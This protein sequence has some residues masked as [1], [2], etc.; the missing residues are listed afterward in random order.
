MKSAYFVCFRWRHVCDT[1]YVQRKV[2]QNNITSFP[3]A[4]SGDHHVY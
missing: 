1:E 3:H 2:G 4:A